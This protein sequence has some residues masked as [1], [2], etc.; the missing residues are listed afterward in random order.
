MISRAPARSARIHQPHAPVRWLLGAALGLAL[1]GG[2]AACG[3]RG[4]HLSGFHP[5]GDALQPPL[6]PIV[7]SVLVQ[8]F[9]KAE[10]LVVNPADLAE[11]STLL[12]EDLGARPGIRIYSRPPTTL[13]NTAVLFGTLTHYQPRE[14]RGPGVYLR[15]IDLAA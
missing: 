11:L 1:A 2:L 14:Q 13:P 6:G 9:A 12:S 8:P 3:N 15:T 4:A 10:N 7:D 5:G